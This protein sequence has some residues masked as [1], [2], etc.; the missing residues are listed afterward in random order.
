M[1]E[2]KRANLPISIRIARPDARREPASVSIRRKSGS[3]FRLAKIPH[4]NLRKKLLYMLRL[5]IH[6]SNLDLLSL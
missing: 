3:P 5:Q 1:R 4:F 2:L 6:D